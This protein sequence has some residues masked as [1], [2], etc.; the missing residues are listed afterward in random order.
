MASSPPGV[1]A[2]RS[3]PGRGALTGPKTSPRRRTKQIPRPLPTAASRS[4]QPKG[5]RT[6]APSA[7]NVTNRGYGVGGA[8]TQPAGEFTPALVNVKAALLLDVFEPPL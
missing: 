5:R 7:M 4:P 2:T 3:R 8:G 1:S 6:A